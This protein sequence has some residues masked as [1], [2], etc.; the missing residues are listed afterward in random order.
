MEMSGRKGG[1]GGKGSGVMFH[2]LKYSGQVRGIKN[3]R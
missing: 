3:D 1:G 2:L